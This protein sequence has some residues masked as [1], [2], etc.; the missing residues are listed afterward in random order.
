MQ[1]NAIK[2]IVIVGGGTAGWMCAAALSRMLGDK[3]NITLV[4][5][6]QIGTVGVGEATIP[7]IAQFN[8]ML[9][10]DEAEFMAA[11]HG[12]FKLGIEF[13]DW[14]QIGE[15]Y[16][17]PFG[18]HG[19]DMDGVSFHQYW[20]R[21]RASGD[22]TPIEEYSLS[23]A[24]ARASKFI[25]PKADPRSILS[26]MSYAYQFDATA[27]AAYL[28]KYAQA[29]GVK[30]IEGL[31]EHV[32][33][34]QNSGFITSVKLQDDQDI[35]GDLFF[36]CTGFRALLIGKTLGVPYEDWSHW[37]PCD[38]AQAV[39]CDINGPV[40]PYT[41]ATARSAGWQWRIPTQHRT[42]NG[43]VYCSA[44]MSDDEAGHILMDNLDGAPHMDVPKQ[45]RFK[46]GKRQKLWDKN[47]ISLGLSGGFLEPLESTSIYLIQAGIS[48]FM[49]LF[50]D[51]SMP[52]IDRDEYNSLL[53]KEFDQ[54][55]DF[56]ILHYV[57]TDRDDSSF[58]NYVRA[59]DIP[60]SLTRKIDLF[61]FSGRFFRYDGELFTDTSWIAVLLGQNIIPQ[62]YDP[63]VDTL[64]LERVKDSLGSMYGAMQNAVKSMPSHQDYIAKFCPS[65]LRVNS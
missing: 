8:Q 2:D 61:K 18:N 3:L 58:W 9:G 22:A 39:A 13:V 1:D 4:E 63:I 27:Y 62:R 33:Q 5:S 57:A 52:R 45:L 55:R 10:I 17:H 40:I 12:T 54:V 6:E 36:D 26:H 19:I 28:R 48:R 65:P 24:A 41:R 38:S 11:T 14:G 51:K 21:L 16:L 46:T 42:G 25:H 31:V 32:T 35:R 23:A 44:Y 53:D 29:R 56:L 37:L 20:G 15:S 30:R 49:A 59:M 47:V 50:P 64:D 7:N 43:H 60:E 34:D